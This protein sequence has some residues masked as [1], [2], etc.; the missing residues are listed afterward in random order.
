MENLIQC[1]GKLEVTAGDRFEVAE[2]INDLF[3]TESPVGRL[4]VTL[5]EMGIHA[6]R[7]FQIKEQ[8]AEYVA[9]LAVPMKDN[10]WLSVEFSSNEST[11]SAL[12]LSSDISIDECARIIQQ[13]LAK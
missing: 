8:D 11:D 4:F 6:E 2:E 9:D 10:A 3:E 1:N 7:N 13:Q 12:H 5:K